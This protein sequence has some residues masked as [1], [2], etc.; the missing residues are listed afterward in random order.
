MLDTTRIKVAKPRGPHPDKRLTAVA[1][2]NLKRPGRYADGNGLYL[3]VDDSGAK[4]WVLRTVIN[5]KRR[6]VGL[7]S[8][9]LV[10]LADAREEARQLRRKARDGEDPL[11]ERRRAALPMLTFEDAAKQVHTAHAATFR[12]E[13]HK[14]QWLA[15]LKAD[16]FPV[17]GRQIVSAIESGDVLKVLSRSGRRS[18]KRR[19]G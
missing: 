18:P 12:N 15:S 1:I 19:A 17:I 13:K 10:S 3:F 4:R 16:V 6:D 7:G 9:R 11:A 5:G 8:V 2:R 14:A